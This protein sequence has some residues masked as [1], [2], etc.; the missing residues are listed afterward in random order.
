[1]GKCKLGLI[2]TSLEAL[3]VDGVR[4][5]YGSSSAPLCRAWSHYSSSEWTGSDQSLWVIDS[6]GGT[7]TCSIVV[8]DRDS[9]HRV[10]YSVCWSSA[11]ISEDYVKHFC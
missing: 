1:M 5:T 10:S 2:V 3:K 8:E 11:S 7:S 9:D 6:D 4:W